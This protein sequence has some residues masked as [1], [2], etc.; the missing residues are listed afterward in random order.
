[1]LLQILTL[2]GALGMFLFGMNMMSSGLQ[3]ASGDKLRKLL[4]SITSNRFK[5]QVETM[6]VLL[7]RIRNLTSLMIHSSVRLQTMVV[8]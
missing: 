6:L 2:L 5:V 4:S 8:M 7:D 1:M 3:K